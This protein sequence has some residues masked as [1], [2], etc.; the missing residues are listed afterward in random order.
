MFPSSDPLPISPKVA[1][2]KVTPNWL[3]SALSL[4]LKIESQL[5]EPRRR[6]RVIRGYKFLY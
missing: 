2:E 6:R 4:I 5:G 1:A 3:A